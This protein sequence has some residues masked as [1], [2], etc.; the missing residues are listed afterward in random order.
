MAFSHLTLTV[1][2]AG[3]ITVVRTVV[4]F[5]TLFGAVD[6]GSIA[7]LELIRTT[8]EQGWGHK[9]NTTYIRISFPV[10]ITITVN[11]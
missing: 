6:A 11:L 4:N 7:T 9:T 2:T 3:F 5:I 10:S 1:D 8:R